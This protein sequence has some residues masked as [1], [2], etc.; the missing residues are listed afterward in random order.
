MD[1]VVQTKSVENSASLGSIFRLS[2]SGDLIRLDHDQVSEYGSARKSRISFKNLAQNGLSFAPTGLGSGA[3][4]G[5]SGLTPPGGRD[6]GFL[7][8][9]RAGNRLNLNNN[10][11]NE[12][13]SDEMAEIKRLL[14]QLSTQVAKL[15]SESSNVEDWKEGYHPSYYLTRILG[16]V[17]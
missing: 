8:G 9:T 4:L 11:N 2:E 15:D 17:R 16:L 14:K 6:E 1:A 3:R 13:G 7:I 12:N 5:P 10:T